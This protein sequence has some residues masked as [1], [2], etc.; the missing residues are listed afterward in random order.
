MSSTKFHILN[1]SPWPLAVSAASCATVASFALLLGN[2]SFAWVVAIAT[3]V[4]LSV[5]IGLWCRD[6]IKES[7]EDKAH[8]PIVRHGLRMGMALF[9]ITELVLFC[10]LFATFF[11]F[12]L[13]PHEIFLPDAGMVTAE[14]P[15]KDMKLVNPVNLPLLNTFILLLSGSTVTWAHHE[16]KQKNNKSAACALMLTVILGATFTLIQAFEYMHIPFTIEI[17]NATLADI[18]PT[19]FFVLT[20]FHGI[21]V[22]IGTIFLTVCLLL[23]KK[24]KLSVENHL[25]LEFAAWYWHFVDVIWLLLFILLYWIGSPSN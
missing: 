24:D 25:S 7:Y 3:V 2:I 21:H 16:V 4:I 15:P 23:A 8:N 1:P 11:R 18:Y 22:L 9:I 13:G 17:G 6:I 5:L 19:N 14:W 12:W 20:G 10:A